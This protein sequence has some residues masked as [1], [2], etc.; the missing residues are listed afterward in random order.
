MPKSHPVTRFKYSD[1]AHCW[2]ETSSIALVSSQDQAKLDD[3]NRPHNFNFETPYLGAWL[4]NWGRPLPS[5]PGRAGYSAEHPKPWPAGP[6]LENIL[7]SQGNICHLGQFWSTHARPGDPT[8]RHFETQPNLASIVGA[9]EKL[10]QTLHFE[11]VGNQL[12]I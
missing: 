2:P 10:F 9:L 11:D 6:N 4:P 8:F 1:T 5:A 3:Q 12:K 7:S